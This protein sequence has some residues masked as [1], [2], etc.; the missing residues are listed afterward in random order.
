MCDAFKPM[1]DSD[2]VL[3]GSLRHDKLLLQMN[4][5]RSYDKHVPTML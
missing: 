5:L 2:G 3:L 4:T 1:Y